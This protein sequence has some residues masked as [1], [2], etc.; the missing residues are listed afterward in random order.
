[1]KYKLTRRV[2]RITG[3]VNECFQIY[4]LTI[5]QLADLKSYKNLISFNLFHQLLVLRFHILFEKKGS[6]TIKALINETTKTDEIKLAIAEYNATIEHHS[7]LIEK[8]ANQRS[9]AVAHIDA[10]PKEKGGYTTNDIEV[11]LVA[12]DKLLNVLNKKPPFDKIDFFQKI[13]D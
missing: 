11:V 6:H 12:I 5:H 13:R 1:M 4:Y 8:I 7:S 9:E 10:F 3:L 2:Q